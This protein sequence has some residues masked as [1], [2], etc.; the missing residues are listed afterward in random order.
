MS[1]QSTKRHERTLKSYT[2]WKKPIFNDYIPYESNHMTFQK[3]QNYGDKKKMS[4]YQGSGKREGWKVESRRSLGKWT[5]SVWD[6]SE[7]YM[8]LDTC[9]DH[10]LYNTKSELLE[11][12]WTLCIY[13]ASRKAHRLWELYHS[14][15][16]WW[17]W[18]TGHVWEFSVLSTQF[19]QEPK[20]TLKSQVC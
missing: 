19:L 1:Y 12:R 11:K 20:T 9:E 16:G 5:Y 2:V 15:G 6:L 13:K 17:Q 18:A 3:R 14:G 4:D 8:S 7:G 10:R